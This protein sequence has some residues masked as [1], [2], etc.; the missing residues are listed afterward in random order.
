MLHNCNP[1]TRRLW[2]AKFGTKGRKESFAWFREFESLYNIDLR[3]DKFNIQLNWEVL[4]PNKKI[5][6]CLKL[7]TEIHPAPRAKP[8]I[9]Q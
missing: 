8:T 3:K 1:K 5:R 7:K 4:F 9:K 2:I 6:C